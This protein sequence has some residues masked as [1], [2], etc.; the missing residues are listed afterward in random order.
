V[1]EPHERDDTAE[2][3]TAEQ[4]HLGRTWGGEQAGLQDGETHAPTP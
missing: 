3:E 2:Q 1:V 4:E